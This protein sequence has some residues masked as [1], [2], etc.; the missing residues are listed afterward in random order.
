[1]KHRNHKPDFKAKA[2][3]E[4]LQE[5][6]SLSEI[7][8][9]YSINP[10]LLRR[11]KTQAIENMALIFEDGNKEIKAIE[12]EY[13]GKIDVLYKEIGQL[14]TELSWLKKKSKLLFE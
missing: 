6:K 12:A 13:Q 5:E 2:V 11:W 10:N 1:M 8:S 7:A 14:T 9:K 3:L 4:V